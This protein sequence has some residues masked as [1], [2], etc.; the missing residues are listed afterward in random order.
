MSGVTSL[1]ADT[2]FACRW[3]QQEQE[4]THCKGDLAF[5]TNSSS[6]GQRVEE[7]AKA[8]NTAIHGRLMIS[9]N[10]NSSM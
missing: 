2:H 4:V 10:Q 5:A 3:D 1:I 6:L 7:W 9:S 8:M